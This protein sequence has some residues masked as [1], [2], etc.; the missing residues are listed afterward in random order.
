[1]ERGR[2]GGTEGREKERRKEEEK[3]KKLIICLCLKHA[4]L[5]CSSPSPL[6]PAGDTFSQPGRSQIQ[7]GRFPAKIHWAKQ[8]QHK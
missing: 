2:D 8:F 5:L 3:S 7:D 4:F 6:N 1:M